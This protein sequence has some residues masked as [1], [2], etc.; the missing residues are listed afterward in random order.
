MCLA[1]DLQK[2]SSLFSLEPNKKKY[3]RLSSAA[4]MIGTLRVNMY[5]QDLFIGYGGNVVRETVKEK[6][7]WFVTDFQELI[8]A[9]DNPATGSWW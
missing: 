5:F 2:I 8:R 9:L 4:V 3:S 7:D 1:E 6:A